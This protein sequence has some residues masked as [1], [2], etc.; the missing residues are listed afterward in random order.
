MPATATRAAPIGTGALHCALEESRDRGHL[1]DL[2]RAVSCIAADVSSDGIRIDM[3]RVFELMRE[4]GY[5][6]SEP[7]RPTT[8]R[9]PG[10][11]TWLVDVT[12]P[13]AGASFV[14][15]FD[16]PNTS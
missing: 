14:W 9:R 3:L 8:Q 2:C 10:R 4:R 6:V 1:Q 5:Q 16:V 11:T 7:R 12:L 13:A 15:A